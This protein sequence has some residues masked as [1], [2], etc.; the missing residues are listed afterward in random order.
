MAA[1][2]RKGGKTTGPLE[3]EEGARE[4]ERQRASFSFSLA[5]FPFPSFFQTPATPNF[6]NIGTESTKCTDSTHEFIELLTTANITDVAIPRV[7]DLKFLGSTPI[8]KNWS[9]ISLQSQKFKSPIPCISNS[10]L[11]RYPVPGG[12]CPCS[13]NRLPLRVSTVP[14]HSV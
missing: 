5:R 3:R 10:H 7:L 2:V 4:K 1:D 12:I 6:P 8:I 13:L 9:F 11:L 14:L